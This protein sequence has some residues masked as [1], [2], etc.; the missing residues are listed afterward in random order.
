M[1]AEWGCFGGRGGRSRRYA[2]Q[3]SE[4]QEQELSSN[5]QHKSRNME[6]YKPQH[7]VGIATAPLQALRQ[8]KSVF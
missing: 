6:A 5:P 7:L 3:K 1:H 2:T 8:P 4:T